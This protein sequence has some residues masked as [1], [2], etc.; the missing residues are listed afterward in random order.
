[1]IESA[2]EV[3]RSYWG[4]P[5]FRPGQDQIIEAALFRRDVLAILPT[6]GGKSICYQVPG[7]LADG[8]TLVISP[9][10]ALM[11]DQVRHLSQ[12]GIKAY[13]I[14]SGLSSREIAT[15]LDNCI[16]S[17][18]KFLY[19]SPERLESGRFR[20]SLPYLPVSQVAID[21]AHCISQWGH[22]FRPAYQ[23]IGAIREIFPKVPF[24]A[25]TAT[26]TRRVR[27]DIVSS[28][29]LRDPFIYADSIYRPNLSLRLVP[30]EDRIGEI[31]GYC[32]Q[33]RSDCGIIYVRNRKAC[34]DIS[35][36]LKQRGVR[37]AA[38][39]AGLEVEVR[40]KAMQDWMNG[41]VSVMVATNAFGMGIDKADVR[42]V[43][44]VESPP[45]L[46]SY[47]QEAGRAGRDGLPSEAVLYHQKGDEQRILERW[48]EQY[49]DVDLVRQVYKRLALDYQVAVGDLPEDELPLDLKHISA[50]LQ[51]SEK[52][53]YY[54]LKLLQLGGWIEW[55]ANAS[56]SAST[57]QIT[58]NP[59]QLPDSDR[60][61]PFMDA[62]LRWMLRLYEGILSMPV[63]IDE[64]AL[65]NYLDQPKAK[66]IQALTYLHSGGFAEYKAGTGLPVFR[67][68]VPR[69][70]SSELRFEGS[71]IDMIQNWQRQKLGAVFQY[72][73]GTHCLYSSLAK[74]FDLPGPEQCGHC[75]VC[76]EKSKQ[77]LFTDVQENLLVLIKKGPIDM[78]GIID[79]FGASYSENTLFQGLERLLDEE[80]IILD[81]GKYQS[82]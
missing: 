54:A 37:A 43:L 21:E 8:L 1:M 39:H 10:I 41:D 63:I 61:F 66:V 18:V 11:D 68:I 79:Q 31:L 72:L 70:K 45:D 15:I 6:G 76:F 32:V 81:R 22:D 60:Y 50:E 46:E 20:A 80:L 65:S 19:I 28:L 71:K 24:R 55:N 34:I 2:K 16:N 56:N 67:F 58:V 57:F 62:M 9:L 23:R 51:L 38:Y 49:I 64:G 77:A 40:S 27:E 44:H 53:I 4:H 17:P 12:K 7:M 29:G 33:H 36:A 14:H 35:H 78:K 52:V 59:G 47:Y 13:R 25:F 74:Y 48:E 69:I 30:T 75:S 73:G 42:Y 26:A 82:P 5:E 3:L